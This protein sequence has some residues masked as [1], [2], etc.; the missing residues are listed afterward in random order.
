MWTRISELTKSCVNELWTQWWRKETIKKLSFLLPPGVVWSI[1]GLDVV[2]WKKERHKQSMRHSP[3]KFGQLLRTLGKT[4]CMKGLPP[5]GQ[6]FLVE[7]GTWS[8]R[9]R[10]SGRG[11]R[12]SPRRT[13]WGPSS[14]KGR[15]RRSSS[16]ITKRYFLIHTLCY[17]YTY[18]VLV[19]RYR[20]TGSLEAPLTLIYTGVAGCLNLPEE[21]RRS[22]LK[23]LR[24]R[25]G[26][27]VSAEVSIGVFK[28]VY[29]HLYLTK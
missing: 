21:L 19:S 14:I 10:T 11:D 4:R 15:W 7:R 28:S 1:L 27:S 12:Q 24:R 18:W 29:L 23:P 16:S 9:R 22:Q 8:R 3:Y 25:G 5:G 2:M 20:N 6:G 13:T 17:F 26:K